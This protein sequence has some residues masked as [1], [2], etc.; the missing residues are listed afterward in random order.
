MKSYRYFIDNRLV[1]ESSLSEFI[2]DCRGVAP[3]RHTITVHGMDSAY[4]RAAAQIPVI[5]NVK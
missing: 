2:W 1:A 4:N 3:G 5:I